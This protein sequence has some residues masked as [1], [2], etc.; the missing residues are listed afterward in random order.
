[1][2]GRLLRIIVILDIYINFGLLLYKVIII[3]LNSE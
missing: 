3:F 1:M 2:A